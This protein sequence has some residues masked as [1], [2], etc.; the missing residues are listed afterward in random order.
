M[1]GARVLLGARPSAQLPFPSE[2]QASASLLGLGLTQASASGLG[3]VAPGEGTGL[4]LHAEKGDPWES[5]EVREKQGLGR[6]GRSRDRGG[7]GEAGTW[8]VREKQAPT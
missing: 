3:Q 4:S 1:P 2:E 7:Q 8:E 5:W 6:S